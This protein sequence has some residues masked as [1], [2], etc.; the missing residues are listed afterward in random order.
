V[1][2]R[3]AR[4]PEGSPERT[5]LQKREKAL[6]KRYARRW[7]EPYRELITWWHY[8]RGFIESAVVRTEDMAETFTEL[9][10]RCV[11]STPLRGIYLFE[12]FGQPEVLLPAAPYMTRLRE[13][14]VRHGHLH[15]EGPAILALLSSPHLSGLTRLELEGDRNGTWFRPRTLCAILRS[16]VLAGLTDL[17]L[18]DYIRSLHPSVLRAVTTSPALANLR[19]LSIESSEIGRAVARALVRAPYAQRLEVL[20]LRQCTIDHPAWRA[21]L[22]KGNF[23]ALKR[24]LLGGAI[25]DVPGPDPVEGARARF[26]AD[27]VDAEQEFPERPHYHSWW[28]E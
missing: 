28:E 26:G 23:P 10:R 6:L 1:Q 8:Q 13:F 17:S 15:E 20:E 25:L 27:A 19:R 18:G 14:G 21:L 24:L 12:Q 2:C 16:P 7:A 9:F 22:A 11:D 5:A 3:L 4:L